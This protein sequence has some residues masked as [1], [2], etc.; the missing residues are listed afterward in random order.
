MNDEALA[1]LKQFITTI[2]SRQLA[3]VFERLDRID[4]R[5][6]GIDGR[7]DGIDGRLDRIDGRLDRLEQKVD[8]GFAGVGE[9]IQTIHDQMAADKAQV[10]TRLTALET[11]TA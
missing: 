8:D 6:N 2:V 10:D 3:P 5:L 4:G 7:L 9:A 1:D 11:K